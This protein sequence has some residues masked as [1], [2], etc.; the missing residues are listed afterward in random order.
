MGVS[1][2]AQAPVQQSA[3]GLYA[4]LL[5]EPGAVNVTPEFGILRTGRWE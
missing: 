5:L 1:G 2:L 4:E 3:S